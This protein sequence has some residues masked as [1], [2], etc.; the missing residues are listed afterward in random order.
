ML[1]NWEKFDCILLTYVY[2][3]VEDIFEKFQWK[4]ETLKSNQ[5]TLENYF[6]KQYDPK[7]CNK[8]MKI[9]IDKFMKQ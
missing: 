8:N 6:C 1:L 4:L 5:I 2:Y 7:E 3:I 9:N